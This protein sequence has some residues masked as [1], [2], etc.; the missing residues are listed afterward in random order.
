MTMW[1]RSIGDGRT[2]ASCGRHGRLHAKA[3][4]T[5]TEPTTAIGPPALQ[6]SSRPRPSLTGG[7][8]RRCWQGIC[9]MRHA[10]AAADTVARWRRPLVAVLVLFAIGA[11]LA[12]EAVG[13]PTC[14]DTLAEGDASAANIARGYAYSIV[15]M[16]AMPFTLA[17]SFGLYV[18]REMRRQ[19]SAV[20]QDPYRGDV[21]R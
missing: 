16:L 3:N 18:W 15:I 2:D 12:G 1:E 7:M 6:R 13:C 5:M 9:R 8:I 19:R 17:G 10:D 11:M 21:R 14:K 20:D 4:P